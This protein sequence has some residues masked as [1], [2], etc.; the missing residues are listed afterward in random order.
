MSTRSSARRLL[1]PIEDPERL[2]SRQNQSEPSLLFDLEEDDMTG[3]VP[4]QGPSPDLRKM[5]E[6]LKAPTDG[7]VKLNNVPGD[8]VKLL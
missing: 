7:A 8:V 2:L 1:S 3:Q 4:P 5:E 6:L